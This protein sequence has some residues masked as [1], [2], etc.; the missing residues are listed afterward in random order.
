MEKSLGKA[1]DDLKEVNKELTKRTRA[2]TRAKNGKDSWK[3]KFTDVSAKLKELQDEN[4]AA[5]KACKISG[6]STRGA[7]SSQMCGVDTDPDPAPIS[8][9]H[10]TRRDPAHRVRTTACGGA[11][12]VRGQALV[13]EHPQVIDDD[14]EVCR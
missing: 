2:L 13:R 14:R 9:R 3:G 11:V 10:E 8:C 12:L 5:R 7:F 1:T 4:K 6:R